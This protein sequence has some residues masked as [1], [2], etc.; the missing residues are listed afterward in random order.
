V[1]IDPFD[2]VY[3]SFAVYKNV[4]AALN[5]DVM[6]EG[7]FHVSGNE[8]IHSNLFPY[9]LIKPSK[10]RPKHQHLVGIHLVFETLCYLES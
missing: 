3:H 10:H 1:K 8:I 2:V 7:Q 6:Y 9:I 5:E 4:T